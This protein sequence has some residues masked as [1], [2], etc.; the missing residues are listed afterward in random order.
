MP[1][2]PAVC[3]ELYSQL[4][5]HPRWSPWLRSVVF[6]DHVCVCVACVLVVYL[7]E[8]GLGIGRDGGGAGLVR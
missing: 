4:E 5:E 8:G 3:Y 6:L 2:D 7:L 1:A